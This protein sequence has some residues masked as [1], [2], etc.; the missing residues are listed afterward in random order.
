VAIP[1][2]DSRRTHPRIGIIDGGISEAL[3]DWVIERWDNR[4]AT[5]Q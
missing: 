2:R 3:S 5:R 1:V 4:L